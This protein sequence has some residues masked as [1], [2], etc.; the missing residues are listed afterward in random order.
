MSE[1]SSSKGVVV[2]TVDEIGSL[3]MLSATFIV[4][5]LLGGE[6]GIWIGMR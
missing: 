6:F 2:G 5:S 3:S 4:V 1:A